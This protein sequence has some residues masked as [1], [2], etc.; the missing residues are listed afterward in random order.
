MVSASGRQQANLSMENRSIRR[1][2]VFPS[3][4][5]DI[6]LLCRLIKIV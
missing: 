1:I 4:D 5:E 3:H 2:I 6:R